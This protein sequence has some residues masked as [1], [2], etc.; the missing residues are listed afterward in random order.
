M[1]AAYCGMKHWQPGRGNLDSLA[2]P[3]SETLIERILAAERTVE[4]IT[5]CLPLLS[6]PRIGNI[7]AGIACTPPQQTAKVAAHA[8]GD[9]LQ[10]VHFLYAQLGCHT[11]P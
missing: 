3:P 7:H 6:S 8:E 4:G 10:R 1:G 5:S 2:E 9:E 11:D